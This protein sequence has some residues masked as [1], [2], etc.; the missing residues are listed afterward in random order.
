[1]ISRIRQRFFSKGGHIPKVPAFGGGILPPVVSPYGHHTTIARLSVVS[2]ALKIAAAGLMVMSVPLAIYS[3]RVMSETAYIADG[4]RFGCTLTPI[5][6]LQL[7]VAQE[8]AQ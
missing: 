1:M 3:V 7:P 6:D 2:L 4:S 5:E 8:A